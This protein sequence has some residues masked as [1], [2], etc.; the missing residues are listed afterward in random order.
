MSVSAFIASCIL[1]P[2]TAKERPGFGS[3]LDDDS[4]FANPWRR[5][6]PLPDL[7]DS[8]DSSRRRFDGPPTGDRPA[9]SIS[10]GA[11]DW[12]SSRPAGRPTAAEPEGPSSSFKRKG[13]GFSTPDGQT[14]AA[15]KEDVW[16]IGGKFKPTSGSDDAGPKFGSL[17]GRGDMGPPK[18]PA[19]S[20]E[21]SDWRSTV[22][23]KPTTR[24][25]TSR[26]SRREVFFPNKSLII[27]SSK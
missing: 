24:N 20:T 14:G 18:D 22:R 6:G 13:S 27:L 10:E 21:D 2:S 3:G 12:R 5:D 25:S 17:R 1:N 16:T 19:L 8:R 11:N 15:D 4:K 9:P 7:P 26:A 23:P